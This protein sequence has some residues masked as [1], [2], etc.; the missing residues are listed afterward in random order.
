[1][2]TEF[3]TLEPFV[4]LNVHKYDEA[5]DS[6]DEE[7][8]FHDAVSGTHDSE[9]DD[10]AVSEADDGADSEGGADSEDGA[11]SETNGADNEADDGADSEGG[12]DNEADG[13][14]S[15][16]DGA[17]SEA[18]GADSEADGADSEA[19]GADSEADDDSTT[20]EQY[21][22]HMMYTDHVVVDCDDELSAII[23]EWSSEVHKKDAF[24]EL[25]ELQSDYSTSYLLA[26]VT[27]HSCYV[28][29]AGMGDHATCGEYI[30]KLTIPDGY[31]NEPPK[32]TFMTTNGVFEVGQMIT[33]EPAH[34][35]RLQNI[36]NFII[37]L[38]NVLNDP[39]GVGNAEIK[40][41]MT[42][43][44]PILLKN[45]AISSRA[46][47]LRQHQPIMELFDAELSRR[48]C[49]VSHRIIS[50][51]TNFIEMLNTRQRYNIQMAST[52][53]NTVVKNGV[54]ARVDTD[55][56]DAV[57]VDETKYDEVRAEVEDAGADT[58]AD[59]GAG[60]DT[61]ADAGAEADA[62][63]DTE[64][65]ADAGAEAGADVE[66]EADA[67][68]D[69]GAEADE[70]EAEVD[71]AEVDADADVEAE[72]DEDLDELFKAS[73]IG[74]SDEDDEPLSATMIALPNIRK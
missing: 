2:S 36:H 62:D 33:L 48:G 73:V 27:H 41:Q 35:S 10:G 8:D 49:A 70:S 1:L 51:R 71:E 19:N 21:D 29:L 63:A 58:G 46:R 15:E 57:V 50:D 16:A 66:A 3:Y 38:I 42:A 4:G 30:C 55:S 25:L 7:S 26:K 53:L 6:Q 65:G 40:K 60:A 61:G 12:A 67:G 56:L 69:A 74:E 47:N 59:A 37:M 68:A 14:V 22:F 11:V 17:V 64:A 13:A 28:L 43:V 23:S 54:V 31:P 24:T 9:A 5:S 45:I 20:Y 52:P 18:D 34:W 32:A 44:P 39:H 72:V